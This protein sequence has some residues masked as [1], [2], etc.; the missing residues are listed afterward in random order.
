MSCSLF[1]L[2]AGS[3]WLRSTTEEEMSTD[4]EKGEKSK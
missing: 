4:F 3:K 1:D 2:F